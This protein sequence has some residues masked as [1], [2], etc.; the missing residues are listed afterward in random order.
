M[1]LHRISEKIV[2][3]LQLVQLQAILTLILEQEYLLYR[4]S[5]P[6][7]KIHPLV[8]VTFYKLRPLLHVKKSSL[9]FIL[10]R[11]IFLEQRVI[12]QE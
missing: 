8:E 11:N 6:C 5:P 9:M 12:I 4:Q 2:Y 1:I 10:E 3:G 7:R